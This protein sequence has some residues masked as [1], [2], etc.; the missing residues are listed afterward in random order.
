[1]SFNNILCFGTLNPDLIYFVDKLPNRGDDI[2]SSSSKI[3]AGGTA[4]NCSELIALWN[5]PVHVRGNSI[6]KDPMGIFLVNHLKENN[7]QYDDVIINDTSTPTCSIFVDSSGERTIVSSGYETLKWSSLEDL[8]NFDSLILDRYSIQFI[9]DDLKNL[10][11]ETNL[12]I[13][14]AGYQYEINYKLD[15][16][17]VSKDEI[18]VKQANDLIETK[19]V[20]Y[21]LLTSS[22]LP[23]RLISSEGNIEIVPPDFKTINST[24]AG[25]ATAAYIASFGIK[26][27]IPTIKNAC[28][29]G[30]IVAGTNEKPTLE[31]IQEISSLVDVNLR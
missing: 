12:F 23:A 29:A 24:G 2:R 8:N 31:K 30:A 25:D 18:N 1:M 7:I 22:S 10:Q 17:I 16:L 21:I 15:F 5:K 4:I 20:K 9:K 13:C 27:L 28:A 11:N 3:R 6:G 26:D 19:T 14:Q